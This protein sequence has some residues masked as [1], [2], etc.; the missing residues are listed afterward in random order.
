MRSRS[1]AQWAA[2]GLASSLSLSLFLS[3]PPF[4]AGR[5]F[6]QERRQERPRI[7]GISH[8]SVYTSDAVKTEHFYVH[9]LGALKGPDP[10]NPAGVRYYFNGIQFVEV[11]PLPQGSSSVNRLDHIGYNTANAEG[12]RKY[13]ESHGVAVPSM[14]MKG[15]D[16]GQYFEVKDPEGNGVQFVQP[17]TH[18]GSVP[19]NPLSKHMIH[20][21]YLV[22]DPAAEDTF[23]RAL[24]GFRPYWHGGMKDDTTDWISQQV[25]DGTDWFEYMLVEGPEKTGI[26]PSMSQDTLG[27]L[28][29]FSLGVPNMEKAVTLL[30]EGDRMSGKHSPSQIGRDGKWQFNLYD[31]DGIRVEL[32]EFQPAGKPCCSSFLAP[33]PTE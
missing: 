1:A 19:T 23:Y 10:Q 32:M 3:L 2:V 9:D 6:G 20:I 25:P 13:L 7:T 11:L 28:D 24:L 17:P 21:G 12:L 22:H 31:P 4:L 26:P 18:P 16:G 30:Y 29:H 5:A 27:V 14:V 15:N 33:S 8:I